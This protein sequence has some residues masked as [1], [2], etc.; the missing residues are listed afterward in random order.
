[1]LK[2]EKSPYLTII[3]MVFGLTLIYIL[4]G[5]QA[6]P[7]VILVISFLALS[8]SKFS[9]L[10]DALMKRVLSY[11][12]TIISFLFLIPFFYLVLTPFSVLSKLFSKQDNLKLK[13]PLSTNFKSV[14]K[15]FSK[16]SFKK[17]W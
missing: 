7:Y 12:G 4:K 16:E 5:Y 9:I 8:I 3:G 15:T 13:K 1:M 2:K 17:L 14:D 11:L 10:V 6:L